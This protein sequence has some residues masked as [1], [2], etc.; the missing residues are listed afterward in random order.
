MLYYDIHLINVIYQYNIYHLLLCDIW[1]ISNLLRGNNYI[2]LH[3]KL[4]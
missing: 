3:R 1:Y 2:F 4:P